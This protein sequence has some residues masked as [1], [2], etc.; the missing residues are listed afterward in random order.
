MDFRRCTATRT[1]KPRECVSSNNPPLGC[2]WLPQLCVNKMF[3]I[4]AMNSWVSWTLL[5]SM[6][7]NTEV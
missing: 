3:V 6:G 5:V 7:P 1:A 2:D 4:S